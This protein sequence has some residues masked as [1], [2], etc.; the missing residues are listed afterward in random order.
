MTVKTENKFPHADTKAAT[1]LR[2]GLA[3]L[4]AEKGV[5]ARTVATRLEY[6]Q[7]VVLSH[8]ASGRVPIPIDRVEAIA[9]EV[10][11]HPAA[12]LLA[13]LDQRLGGK[14]RQ[15][16]AQGSAGE[17]TGF[18]TDLEEIAGEDLS[19]LS[20]SKKQILREVAAEPDPTRRWLSLSEL[21]IV[22][23]L[24]RKFPHLHDRGLTPAERE[25]LDDVISNI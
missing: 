20:E 18:V 12:F 11:L 14:A 8:M 5:S 15:L 17:T 25:H 22:Q 10:D 7:P 21:P 6:K 19:A 4:K 2:V 1:M 24:R 13:A 3:R 9:R 23:M 16:L